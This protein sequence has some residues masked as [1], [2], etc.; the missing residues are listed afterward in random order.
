MSAS[1]ETP[2]RIALF[3]HSINPRGGVVH[4]L[5]LG[6]ALHEQGHRV[7]IFAPASTDDVMFR[8]SPCHVVLARVTAPERNTVEMVSA[9]IEALKRAMFDAIGEANGDAFDIVHAQDSISGNALA[10]LKHDGAI[11]GFIRTVHHL[12]HFDN[13]QLAHWQRRAWRDADRVLCVS[14]TWTRK[15]HDVHGVSAQTVSNG[16]DAARY[17]A[18]ASGDGIDTLD[19][20][21]LNGKPLVL[22]VGGVEARKN[23]IVL[24]DAFAELR[25]E[26]GD[27]QLVIAGGASLLDHNEY[28]RQF[29]ARAATLG[30]SIGANQPVLVTGSLDDAVMPSLFQCADVVAMVSL[31]EGFG[32]VVLEALAA[33]KPVVASRIEP[34]TEYLDDDLCYWADPHDAGSITDALTSALSDGRIDFDHAVPALLGRFSWS[35]SATRHV[36]LYREWLTSNVGCHSNVIEEL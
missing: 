19:T 1:S 33:G 4:T 2:L 8:E 7:T 10:E 16:V 12:D 32:L 31:R 27:A 30:L 24:L 21:G 11:R 15:M 14:E 23:T 20:L 25:R 22:A 35:A 13:P 17:G 36:D 3:T 28:A 34:F 29:V 6:K 18:I 5:E 26:Y 9:R